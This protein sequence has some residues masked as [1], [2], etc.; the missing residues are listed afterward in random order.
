MGCTINADP[1]GLESTYGICIDNSDENTILFCDV[2]NASSYGIY[3]S[4]SSANTVFNCLVRENNRGVYLSS[5]TGNNIVG[6]NI[7]NNTQSGVNILTRSSSDNSILFNDF[8]DNG[9]VFYPQA[10]DSGNRNIWNTSDN[11]TFLYGGFGEGNHWSDYNGNDS[12]GDGIGDTPYTIS[13]TARAKDNYPVMQ[14][15]GWFDDWF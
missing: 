4:G 13:G 3:L 1:L 15:Y 9:G 10:S 11:N 6:N 12:D 7:S 2:F 5:S 8:I 14:A